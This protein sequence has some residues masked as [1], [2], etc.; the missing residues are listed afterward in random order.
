M[1]AYRNGLLTIAALAM[2]GIFA[3]TADAQSVN[4]QS[5]VG[6]R[7]TLPFEAKWAHTVLS[8]GDYTVSVVR[9]TNARDV[10]YIV[11]FAGGDKT[12]TILAARPTGPQAGEKSML[13]AERRGGIYTISALHLASANLL[14]T[15][16]VPKTEQT[17]LAGAP[18]LFQSVPVQVATK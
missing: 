12:T 16:P 6:G 4:A 1:K 5:K 13:V 2:T 18:E 11:T 15:F 10:N 17:L 9:L 7:F 3:G 14:L 8:P